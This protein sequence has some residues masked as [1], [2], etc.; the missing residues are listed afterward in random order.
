MAL[1]ID[2]GLRTYDIE[3]ADGNF[4]G[5]IRFNPADIGFVSRWQAFQNRAAV[6]ADEPPRTPQAM[7][8]ADEELKQLMDKVFA[9]PCADVL[10]QG[11]SCFAMC[12]DGRF[13]LT[14]VLEALVP[15]MKN[16]I[17]QAQ[18]ASAERMAK[19]TAAYEGSTD[20]LAPG[21]AAN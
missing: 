20:G 6:L 2:L 7:A 13:I 19:H 5:A 3:D 21:Q 10:L 12:M 1:K 9:A 11:Q 8:A 16:A 4:V 14:N 17:E 15:V 18:K